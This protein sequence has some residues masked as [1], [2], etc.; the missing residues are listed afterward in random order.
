M[1]TQLVLKIAVSALALGTTMVGC[2]SAADASRPASASAASPKSEKQ[3]ADAFASAQLAARGGHLDR[4]LTL[5]EKAVELSPRDAG[6]RVNLADLYLKNGRFQSA[7]TTYRDVLA[8]NPEN[9]HAALSL[10]LC[11]I[12]RGNRDGAVSILDGLSGGPVADLGL[13]YALA[14]QPQRAVQMLEPAAR[15]PGADARLR[16]NLAFSYALAGNWDKARSTAAQ[17]ISPADLGPRLAQWAALAQPANASD[18][19]A[20]LLGVRPGADSGQPER[21]ALAPLP[22]APALAAADPVPAATPAAAPVET[23]PIE[24][25]RAE[26]LPAVQ[27]DP[28]PVQVAAAASDVPAWMSSVR[29]AS[30]PSSSQPSAVPHANMARPIAAPGRAMLRNAAFDRQPAPAFRSASAGHYAVQLGAFRSPTAL[31]RAWAQVLRRFGFDDMIPLSTTVEMPGRGTFHRLSVA[32][33]DS[34]AQADRTCGAIRAKGGA[35]FVRTVAG[36]S[37]P[38]WAARYVKG[39]KARLA[40][41]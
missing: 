18:Q 41:R 32:G 16:Q 22:S 20:A 40:S 34:R 30:D 14:G 2:K 24:T 8:L 29:Q 7:E 27:P 1:K 37:E 11:E 3:A 5:V 33:F 17:D 25:A 35:C 21:L 28:A 19:V 38:Q 31:E 36:D 4:A 15:A 9:R 39:G 13:A 6:Y 10:V 26:P 23:A 12:A